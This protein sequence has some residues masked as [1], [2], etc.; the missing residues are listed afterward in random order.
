MKESRQVRRK[1]E[2]NKKAVVTLTEA[3]VHRLRMAKARGQDVEKAAEAEFRKKR[4]ENTR[5]GKSR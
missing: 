1:R 2:R 4:P 3:G 5:R